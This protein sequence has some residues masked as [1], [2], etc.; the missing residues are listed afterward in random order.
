MIR[1]QRALRSLA[2]ADYL[3]FGYLVLLNVAVLIAPPNPERLH[4]LVQVIGLLTTF[5]VSMLLVR[6]ELLKQGLWCA[7][8]YRVGIYGTVQQSYFLFRH[9]LP[10]VNPGSLDHELYA[11]DLKLFGVE[12]AVWMDQFVTPTTTEWFAFFYF[13]YFF[14]LAAHVIP[15]VFGARR[16]MLLGEFMLGML[17]IVCLGHTGYILVP[18]FGPYKAM[19]ELFRNEL[20]SGL[21]MDLVWST[22]RSGGAM[23]DIFP[24]LHT[25]GPCFIAMFSFR[26]RDRLPFRF[27]WPLLAFFAANIIGAT[28][29]LRWHYV[30]DVLAGF[31][32]AT[33]AAIVAPKITRWEL[34]RRQAG[35]LGVL[36]PLFGAGK[37]GS[38][39]DQAERTPA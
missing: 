27:T 13:C 1:V 8:L 25:A 30:I 37:L 11:L 16:Q 34:S 6:G 29:F 2:T 31:A 18:G 23:K 24:S 15:I 36:V 17:I 39:P 9:L 21:W 4:C 28:M 32:L 7:L 5:L 33:T 38:A 26:N 10:V 22:V 14:L 3:V 35:G 20:P 12:P 19:P